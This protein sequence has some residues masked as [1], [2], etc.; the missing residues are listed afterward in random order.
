MLQLVG[1]DSRV[2][3]SLA[4]ASYPNRDGT[5]VPIE[6]REHSNHVMASDASKTSAV[7]Q[8]VYDREVVRATAT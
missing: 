1:P 2:F 7:T 3:K 6:V 4:Q 8:L 5:P